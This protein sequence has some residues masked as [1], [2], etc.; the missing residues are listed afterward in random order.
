MRLV[1]MG[2][3]DFAVPALRSLVSAGHDVVGVFCQPDRP[4]GRGHKMMAPPVKEE[5]VKL[6]IPVYQPQSVKTDEALQILK[7]LA[8]QCIVVVAYGKLLPK[9]ILDLPEYGCVN[10]HASLLPHYR[11]AAPIQWAV[12]NGDQTTGVTIMKMDEGMDTGDILSVEPMVI[13]EDMTAGELFDALSELG[14]KQIVTTLEQLEKGEVT[15][16]SQ[17]HEQASL[18]PMLDRSLSAMEFTKTARALHNL[19]RGLN[20]WPS[21]KI[22]VDGVG[23]KIHAS[24]VLGPCNGRPGE[25]LDEKQFV[26]CCGDGVALRL[27]QV[28]P[29]G[30]RRMADEDFLRGHPIAKGTILA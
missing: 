17:N 24:Q 13:P 26:I 1:F 4:R 27:T 9:T 16:I 29:D 11:G 5:A 23:M 10:I 14:G 6:G 2:T 8:P 20:P 30:S 7:D 25:V 21:A 15:P 22:T 28:Q 12:I 3:P 18:A 19:I